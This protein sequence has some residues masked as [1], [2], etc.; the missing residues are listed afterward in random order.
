[1]LHHR[2][3]GSPVT[4]AYPLCNATGPFKHSFSSWYTSFGELS[5]D[6][7]VPEN[8]V[9]RDVTPCSPLEAQR[10]FWGM[11]LLHLQGRRV[12]PS[13]ACRP[14]VSCFAYSLALKMEAIC[15][16]E[17]SVDFH[18][19]TRLCFSEYS[20]LHIHSWDN[21]KSDEIVS[22]HVNPISIFVRSRYD[23]W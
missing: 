19:I 9:F 6:G 20:A 14:L 15:Y 22:F 13:S 7:I 17:T 21:L 23:W 3:S 12:S 8:V 11:Y 10:R 4:C 1:M 2:I 18:A 16:S 5:W